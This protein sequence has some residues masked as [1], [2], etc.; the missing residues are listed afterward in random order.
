MRDF[1][2]QR[3]LSPGKVTRSLFPGTKAHSSPASWAAKKTIRIYLRKPGQLAVFIEN[4]Q[5]RQRGKEFS[6]N[7]FKEIH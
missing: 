2:S 7:S 4:R 5:K 6:F 3:S 1:L